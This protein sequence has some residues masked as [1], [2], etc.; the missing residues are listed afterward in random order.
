M[1]TIRRAAGSGA[2]TG[3]D[4]TRH[5]KANKCHTCILQKATRS[6]FKGSLTKAASAIGDVIHTDIAGPLPPTLSGYKYVLIFIDGKTR[7][8]HTYLLMKK[9][10]AGA[11]LKEFVTSFEQARCQSEDRAW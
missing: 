1:E 5:K 2:I 8:M 9:S 11:K 10:E 6:P 7:L 4:L 3:I